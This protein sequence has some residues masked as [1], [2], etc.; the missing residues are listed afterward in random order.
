MTKTFPRFN[1]KGGRAFPAPF[2]TED[3]IDLSTARYPKKHT[4][5][6]V[7]D[8]GIEAACA[9]TGK[10]NTPPGRHY[11]DNDAHDER[12]MPIGPI[13]DLEAAVRFTHVT[14]ALADRR[15]ITMS[16]DTQAAGA[17][18]KGRQS[19]HGGTGAALPGTVNDQLSR[20]SRPERYL[21]QICRETSMV[22]IS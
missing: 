3:L 12:L 16:Y 22:P 4:E 18:C 8:L 14:A 10:S 9:L 20:A 19:R 13:A 6:L 15:A 2:K 17:E 5:A 7:K 11:S 21:P 1:G